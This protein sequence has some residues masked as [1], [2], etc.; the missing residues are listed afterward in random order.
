MMI[1]RLVFLGGILTIGSIIRAQGIGDSLIVHLKNGQRVAI[2]LSDIR[3]ITFDTLGTSAV[4]VP[5]PFQGGGQGVVRGGVYPNPVKSTTTIDFDLPHPGDVSIQIFNAD[6]KL[7]RTINAP[8]LESGHNQIRWDGMNDSAAPV[9][10]GSYFF[11]VSSKGFV[12][13]RKAVV[14][15]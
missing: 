11:E 14:V 1:F 15:R 8:K 7:I 3:K 5:P 4:N 9:Q 10:S 13:S 6:G 2:P 12:Q